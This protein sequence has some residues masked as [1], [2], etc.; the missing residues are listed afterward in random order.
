MAK[1]QL[2]GYQGVYLITFNLTRDYYIGSSKN[3]SRRFVEHMVSCRKNEHNNKSFQQAY[4]DNGEENIS[5]S[6]IERTYSLSKFDLE[7]LETNYIL[8]L[9]PS[10][11][12][13]MGKRLSHDLAGENNTSA[14]LTNE[15]VLFIKMLN[16][17]YMKAREIFSGFGFQAKVN[18]LRTITDVI[19][20]TTWYTVNPD[21]RDLVTYVVTTPNGQIYETHYLQELSNELDISVHHLFRIASSFKEDSH[22]HG[23]KCEITSMPPLEL[24]YNEKLLSCKNHIYPYWGKLINPRREVIDV[25]A[26]KQFCN[27]NNLDM[28]SISK[29]ARGEYNNHKGWRVL[30]QV[31]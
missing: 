2:M 14:K 11:N 1:R 22:F 26:F 30:S 31:D 29:V 3:I 24:I 27:K 10:I 20:G 18:S 4:Y 23:Y 6:T 9:N 8:K 15:D 13:K 17:Q 7:T 16:S 12:R 28:S 21:P 5:V 25:W 19:N